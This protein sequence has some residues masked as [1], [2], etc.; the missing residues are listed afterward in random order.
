MK[1]EHINAKHGTKWGLQPMG[2]SNLEGTS[3]RGKPHTVISKGQV[4]GASPI[5]FA[6]SGQAL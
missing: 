2:N 3:S 6:T 4:S 1:Q 5:Q